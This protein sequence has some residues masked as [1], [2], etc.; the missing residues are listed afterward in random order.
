MINSKTLFKSKG[1]PDCMKVISINDIRFIVA[2]YH[3][4]LQGIRMRSLY[5]FV[6]DLFVM[7]EFLFSDLLRMKPAT[8][9]A[10]LSAKYL[11]GIPVESEVFYIKDTHGNQI[12]YEHNG[13]S[14]SI[15]YL[16]KGDQTTNMV[17]SAFLE[18]GELSENDL[19]TMGNDELLDRF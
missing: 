19:M 1:K 11:N 15:K 13:F 9:V 12:N 16:Y 8:L 7:G 6:N 17:L 2:G 3:E 14:I 4:T 5:F 10:T 18:S